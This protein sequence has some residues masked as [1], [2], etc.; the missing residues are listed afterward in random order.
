MNISE[1]FN[2]IVI[3]F[4][5][6]QE[7]SEPHYIETKK[8]L[9]GHINICRKA[10]SKIQCPFMIKTLIKLGIIRGDQDGREVRRGAP[11]CQQT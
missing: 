3:L 8:R 2:I 4:S 9:Y 1:R 7:S 5:T 6:I 11:L 10:F